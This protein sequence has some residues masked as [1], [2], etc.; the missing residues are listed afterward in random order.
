[1]VLISVLC[2]SNFVS[3]ASIFE[4]IRD[5]EPQ[6][7]NHIKLS[8]NFLTKTKNVKQLQISYKNISLMIKTKLKTF[9]IMFVR[10]NPDEEGEVHNKAGTRVHPELQNPSSCLQEDE[11]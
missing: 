9:F 2:K 11:C 10:L 4:Q 5:F 8:P 3:Q 1:M 6:E 7:V